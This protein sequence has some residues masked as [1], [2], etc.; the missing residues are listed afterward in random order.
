MT[1]NQD[2]AEI[3]ARLRAAILRARVARGSKPEVSVSGQS[4]GLTWSVGATDGKPRVGLTFERR[5]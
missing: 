1:A 3:G 4:G 5:F 2:G